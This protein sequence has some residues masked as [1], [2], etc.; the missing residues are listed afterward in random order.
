MDVADI[1]QRS[2]NIGGFVILAEGCPIAF[3]D[4]PA[5]AG[6]G[7]S[8]WIGTSFG[9]REVLLAA[10]KTRPD[11]P[12]AM[13]PDLPLGETVPETAEI[14]EARVT[15]RLADFDGRIAALFA[16]VHPDS[17]TDSMGQRLSPKQDPAPE[18]IAGP[19]Q[20]PVGL[21]GRHIGIEAIGPAGQRRYYWIEPTGAPPG[22]DHLGGV[23]WPPAVITDA[24][25]IW[26]GRKVAVYRIVQDPDTG[27]WPPWDEQHAGGSLWWVG[28]L[29]GRGA[30]ARGAGG[31]REFHLAAT[32]VHSLL[33][34]PLNLARPARWIPV[35]NVGL[36]LEGDALKIAAWIGQE[37]PVDIGD[38]IN[39]LPST[40]DCQTLMSGNT[41]AGCTTREE[42]AARLRDVVYTMIS[43]TDHGA[44][45]A[46]SNAQY[47]GPIPPTD[48][49]YW[50]EVQ[51]LREITISLDGG[52]ISIKCEPDSGAFDG[53]YL[54]LAIDV[55]VVQ[56]LGWDPVSPVWDPASGFLHRCPVGGT[57]WGENYGDE[58]L[59]DLHYLGFFSTKVGSYDE[60]NGK[61]VT[62][63]APYTGG[64]LSLSVSGGEEV[65]LGIGELPC[66][67]QLAQPYTY[68]SQIDGVDVNAAGWWIFRGQRMT[69][70]AYEAGD[71]PEDFAQIAF[72]EWV[73]SNRGDTILEDGSG[74]AKIKIVRREDPRRFGLPYDRLEEPWT[75][76]LGGLECAPLAVLGGL[77]P[78]APGWRHRL[79][80]GLL[81]SSG[82]AEHDDSGGEVELVP[83]VNHPGDVPPG[84]PWPGD[85]EVADLGL[86][87]SSAWVDWASW[88]DCAALLPG[89]AGGPLNR[90]LY[91]S[92]GP[93]Q[94]E[95]VL[96]QAMAGAGWG[97][98]WKRADGE[99]PPRLG[100]W[101]PIAP[102]V[103]A[104]VE[105]TITRGS[106]A[107]ATSP[108]DAN[109]PQWLAVIETRNAGPFDRFVFAADADPIESELALSVQHESLDA[110]RRYRDGK[111]VWGIVD[112]GLRDLR[113]W[114]GKAEADHYRWTE[115][116][117][118]RFA[119]GF[120]PHYARSGR[121]YRD[122]LDAT[123]VTRIGLGTVVHVVN[124]AVEAPDGSIGVN[125][126]GR[127]VDATII[128]R[129]KMQ[130][131]SVAVLLQPYPI[132]AA[133]VWGPVAQAGVGSWDAD[134]STLTVLEDW[135]GVG[136]G[137]SDTA[138]FVRPP[139]CTL[140]AGSLR[141]WIYQSEDGLDWP[142]GEVASADVVSATATTLSLANIT[143]TI[144]RDRIKWIVAAPR[145]EQTAAWAL[146]LYSHVTDANGEFNSAKGFR[147]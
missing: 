128:C 66:E 21:W 144:Y 84:D 5:L 19:N 8:S 36:V 87:L 91:A 124:P 65:S 134:S 41:F 135:A 49:G 94:A 20:T 11:D 80:P 146:G 64:T 123:Y 81:Q 70:Q 60:N 111:I 102:L 15:F 119:Q 40:F 113:H 37:S 23:G 9:A 78:S 13:V 67:G 47:T 141:V 42:Y 138:G 125:H 140:D 108:A 43:N 59:P 118:E 7:A 92:L 35:T 116:A 1:H 25:V 105:V 63:E 97:W 69:A 83:G 133:R 100:C 32:G 89:G 77:H 55:R 74:Q 136:G 72:C 53:F 17:T 57:L 34:K 16:E 82:T 58:T 10:T 45:L 112:G 75:T 33:R 90:V 114:L 50:Q 109:G 73:A 88:Y 4:T 129:G 127:V 22:L 143:G 54:G 12:P 48:H 130:A 86:G 61:V 3:T 76:A 85:V 98:S 46:S 68:G 132:D 38:G 106:S 18:F 93:V 28:Q 27:L 79:I 24:P 99:G 131:V 139:W 122:I 115:P 101:D 145:D 120:G 29:K 2:H 121:L 30:F 14:R 44:V 71:D 103:P 56:L 51:P 137:H 62:Y 110:G 107:E 96:R 147:L 142:S 31:G 117:R 39:V 104:D 52:A 126:L 6:S 26:E 95:D